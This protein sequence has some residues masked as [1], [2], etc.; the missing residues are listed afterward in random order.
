M[1]LPLLR[2]AGELAAS[3]G[4][5]LVGPD[6]SLERLGSLESAD[7]G[8][9]SFVDEATRPSRALHS[10][11]GALLCP[12]ALREVLAGRTLLLHPAPR[13]ALQ[14]LLEGPCAPPPLQE[15]WLGEDEVLARF[16]SR[17]H[18][19]HVDAGAEVDPSVH[20]SPGVV[21]HGRTKVAEGCVLEPGAILFPGTI[22]DR[23]CHIGAHTVLGSQGF[24]LVAGIGGFAPLPHHAGVRLGEG[25]R[26]GP[27]CN[28]AA[29]LL[30]PTFLDRSCQIDAQVQI[31]HN[32]RVGARTRIAAQV[33]L[34]GSVTLGEDC[35][36]GGQAGFADHVRLGDGCVVAAR[37]GVTRPWPAGTQLGGFPAQ[38]ISLWRREVAR[39]RQSPPHRHP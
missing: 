19:T 33:G 7:S 27:Q 24:G 1:P 9:L 16:G 23:N 21:V 29:G 2:T 10:R 17:A 39:G 13:L 14:H 38:P 20:L 11:A 32:C 26:L 37:S 12:F 28:V 6:Q 30:D 15:R 5:E 34:S 8:D 36:V 25:V 4:A 3:L 18:G 35:L 22:L 31:G